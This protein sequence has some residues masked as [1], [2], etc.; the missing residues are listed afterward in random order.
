MDGCR[1]GWLCVTRETSTGRIEARILSVIDEVLRLQPQDDLLDAFIL[2]WTAQR[3]I[4]GEAATLPE[5]PLRDPH[6]LR[7]E[8]CT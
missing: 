3:I 1:G 6:G 4:A 5:A 8:I 7:M 2:L